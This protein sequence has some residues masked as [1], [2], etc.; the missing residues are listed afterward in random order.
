MDIKLG[1]RYKDAVTGF[2]G[3]AVEKADHINGCLQYALQ[4]PTKE[5]GSKREAEWFDFQRLELVD[6]GVGA[7]DDRTAEDLMGK[8]VLDRITK[9]TGVVVCISTPLYGEV[10]YGVRPTVD[11]DGAMRASS[12]FEFERLEVVAEKLPLPSRAGGADTMTDVPP[13]R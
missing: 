6:E 9:F 11:K 10:R 4:P 1:Q 13:V 5:D 3:V 7:V 2:I 12:W 8:K